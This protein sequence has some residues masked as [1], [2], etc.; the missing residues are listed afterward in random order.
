[1]TVAIIPASTQRPGASTKAERLRAMLVSPDLE[2][3][4]EAHDGISAK[5]VEESG[6]KGIWASGLTMSAAIG[7]ARQ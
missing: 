3:L 2:F 1:M 6:F 7:P 5:I 4:M